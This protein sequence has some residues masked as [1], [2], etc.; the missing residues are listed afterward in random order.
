MSTK[1]QGPSQSDDLMTNKSH[2]DTK[3][4]VVNIVSNASNDLVIQCYSKFTNNNSTQ[5]TL[6]EH[7]TVKSPSCIHTSQTNTSS[8]HK[9]H[10]STSAQHHP[11][12]S[13]NQ[14]SIHDT[15]PLPASIPKSSYA[16]ELRPP[17]RSSSYDTSSMSLHQPSS[18][19]TP[20]PTPNTSRQFK[21]QCKLS[22]YLQ[23]CS[24]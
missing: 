22:H 14:H 20:I 9:S 24:I 2:S 18:T 5:S 21:R 8:N 15:N 17:Q 12:P 3:L 23:V 6:S 7:L 10:H 11:T 16:H 19:P 13:P 1:Q 4:Q